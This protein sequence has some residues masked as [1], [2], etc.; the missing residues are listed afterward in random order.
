MKFRKYPLLD[1]VLSSIPVIRK[2]DNTKKR[3]TP[4]SPTKK[5]SLANANAG[6]AAG[7]NSL[8]KRYRVTPTIAM[9]RTPSSSRQCCPGSQTRFECVCTAMGARY[10]GFHSLWQANAVSSV[11]FGHVAIPISTTRTPGSRMRSFT[12]SLRRFFA[13]KN[14]LE[15]YFDLAKK[16]VV[17]DAINENVPQRTFVDVD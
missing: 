6:L 15:P 7:S 8:L 9:P 12:G 4:R 14:Y 2:P 11:G 17:L 5:H 10:V 1:F 16:T 3:S 13:V